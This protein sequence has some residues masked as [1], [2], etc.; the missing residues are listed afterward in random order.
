MSVYKL[1]TTT[2]LYYL[3]STLI[4]FGSH[5]I[6]LSMSKTIVLTVFLAK[7][8]LQHTRKISEYAITYKNESND[9]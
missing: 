6:S 1:L 7:P 2:V 9:L 5:A 4:Y 8:L 3:I